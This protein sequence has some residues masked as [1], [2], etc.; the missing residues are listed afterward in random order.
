MYSILG[1]SLAISAVTLLTVVTL[2]V[3]A[4]ETGPVDK[5]GALSTE[6][7]FPHSPEEH[8]PWV[9]PVRKTTISDDVAD[10]RPL[11]ETNLAGRGLT[12]TGNKNV[13][14]GVLTVN[15]D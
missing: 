8:Q 1:Q 11:H 4:F 6:I 13:A 2:L 3:A 10:D 7:E 9:P 5:N 12:D 15:R 14:E